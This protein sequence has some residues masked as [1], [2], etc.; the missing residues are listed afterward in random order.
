[1]EKDETDTETLSRRCNEF[2]KRIASLEDAL[3]ELKNIT[4]AD[5]TSTFSCYDDLKDYCNGLLERDPGGNEVWGAAEENLKSKI[6]KIIKRI[7]VK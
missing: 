6:Y 7:I 2:E 3:L 1:M 4:G 5:T